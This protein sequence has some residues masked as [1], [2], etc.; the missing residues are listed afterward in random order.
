[1][2]DHSKEI[3]GGSMTIKTKPFILY[4]TLDR[5]LVKLTEG[6]EI[7]WDLSDKII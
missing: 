1:M 7:K 6:L 5:V 2:A 3:H 4:H